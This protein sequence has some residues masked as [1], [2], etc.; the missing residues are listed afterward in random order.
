MIEA[1]VRAF[2]SRREEW[3]QGKIIVVGGKLQTTYYTPC[4]T[5]K[6]RAGQ[7]QIKISQNHDQNQ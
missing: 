5:G 1:A 4:G 7:N 3:L 2:T 6:I